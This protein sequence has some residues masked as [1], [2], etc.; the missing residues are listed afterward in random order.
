[1]FRSRPQCVEKASQSSRP[2]ARKNENLFSPAT[3]ASE[4]TLLRPQ[5]RDL[6]GSG[7]QILRA[8]DCI[9]LEKVAKPLFRQSQVTLWN[10]QRDLFSYRICFMVIQRLER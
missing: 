1:M 9:L 8:A 3:C 4:K 2:K 6:S 5:V 10:T 7:G